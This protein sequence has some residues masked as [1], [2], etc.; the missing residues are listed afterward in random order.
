MGKIY[1]LPLIVLFLL[2]VSPFTVFAQ[3]QNTPTAT[4]LGV[5]EAVKIALDYNLNLRKTQIDLATTG[6]SERNLWSEIF[7]TINASAGITYSTPLLSE[8]TRTNTANTNYTMSFGLSLGLNAGIPFAMK[9]IQLAHQANILRYEEACN[10]LSIQ[11][12]KRYYSLIAEKNNLL[13]LEEVF[14]Q[15]QRQYDRNEVFF[16]NGFIGELALMQSRLALEN[17]RYN[18]S[19]ANI[20]GVNS[21]AEFLSMLGLPLDSNITLLG[22][23]NI[24][25]ISTDAEA[26]IRNYLPQRPDIARSKQEIQR[27]ENTQRQQSMQSRAPSVNLSLNWQGSLSDPFS[28]SLRAS[29]TLSIPIDPWIPG[30]SRSQ[31]LGRARDSVEKAKIDLEIAENSAKTQIRTLTSM[32]H[33]SWDSILIARLGYQTAQRS[34]Q[35][36]EQGFNSGIVESLVLE[37]ARNNMANARQ[38]LFQSELAYFNMILDLSSAINIDWRDFM[39]TY[40]VPGE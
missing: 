5:E 32:L 27:L 23:I 15:A 35:L 8:T 28:D 30:T 24:Q 10:L 6:Y 39:R 33:N 40:G 26:L 31:S 18:L 36:T 25:R 22:E 21:M 13:L 38:R 17:A 37:D 2:P 34:Y 11:V 14:N 1:L 4:V 20:S 12:T 19:A 3:S 7:P 16:R 9:S 29:A